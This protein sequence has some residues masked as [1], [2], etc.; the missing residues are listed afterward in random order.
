M[1]RRWS[2]LGWIAPWVL[3]IAIGCTG[4]QN[5]E[6][7]KSDD[8]QASRT[9]PGQESSPQTTAK[10]PALEK[11][12]DGAHGLVW[13]MPEGF[14]RE[15]PINTMRMAQYKIPSGIEGTKDGELV[16]FFFGAGQGGAVQ[17][18][19][20]RW[21]SQFKQDDGSDPMKRAKIDTLKSA[22]GLNV[23]TVELPGHY[24][25]SMMGSGPSYDEP[26]WRLYGAVVEG[27]G[28]PWFFKAA[29][30]EAVIQKY[31][32]ALTMLYQGFRTH[33]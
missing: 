31:H 15:I 12:M 28:G 33:S 30:P 18:N 8:S 22:G 23:T 5:Q 26:G 14:E 1:S 10:A 20:E 13:R 27:P 16:A 4:G 6:S 9:T 25:S 7:I 29:G 21:A 2:P 19:I 3:V 11:G 17:A 24:V 32:D